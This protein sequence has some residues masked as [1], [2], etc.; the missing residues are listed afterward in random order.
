MP[1]P[2]INT[3]WVLRKPFLSAYL[4]S[5]ITEQFAKLQLVKTNNKFTKLVSASLT[6]SLSS[7]SKS[8]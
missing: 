8:I 4:S 6:S 1:F 5:Q 2:F 7:I 3:F